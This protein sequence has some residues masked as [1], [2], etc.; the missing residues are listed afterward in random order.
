MVSKADAA[1]CFAK[2]QYNMLDQP[3]AW[4]S[5]LVASESKSLYQQRRSDSALILVLSM[6]RLPV[7][8]S[9]VM[10]RRDVS[11]RL[12]T[13]LW[14]EYNNAEVPPSRAEAFWVRRVLSL[15]LRRLHDSRPFGIGGIPKEQQAARLRLTTEQCELVC[16]ITREMPELMAMLGKREGRCVRRFIATYPVW[17]MQQLNEVTVTGVHD[18][19]AHRFPTPLPP[20]D[21]TIAV[22]FL[23]TWQA[24]HGTTAPRYMGLTKQPLYSPGF[25]VGLPMHVAVFWGFYFRHPCT[26]FV[27]QLHMHLDRRHLKGTHRNQIIEAIKTF[28]HDMCTQENLRGSD[29]EAV[30]WPAVTIGCIETWLVKQAAVRCCAQHG[31]RLPTVIVRYIVAMNHFGDL[32]WPDRRHN[33]FSRLQILRT[34]PRQ[35]ATLCGPPTAIDQTYTREDIDALF[36]ACQ[37]RRDRLLLL[38]L[39]RVG[40]RSAALRGLLVGHMSAEGMALE[41]G[42]RWHRFFI[43]TDTRLCLEAYLAHEHPDQRSPFLFPH[44]T[45]YHKAMPASQLRSWLARLATRAGIVGVCPHITIHSFRRYVVTTLLESKNSMEYVAR[46]IG[47]ASANTTSRYWMTS[48]T[49]LVGQMNIPWAAIDEVPADEVIVSVPHMLL[50]QAR[51]VCSLQ[52][53]SHK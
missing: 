52:T 49:Q 13:S 41:K 2:V 9:E 43:D 50:Q 8:D 40:L 42:G 3:P 38:I 18:W 15:L 25:P 12:L 10:W 46:Y 11:T 51:A 24:Q 31:P 39:S 6:L 27:A 34:I 47:H 14:S 21:A 19:A 16:D 44:H 4:I 32:L 22:R 36:R 26:E 20:S 7:P 48:P 23:S 37:S 5:S 30:V 33:A 29:W 53:M 45:G 35:G 1:N 17:D 28:V